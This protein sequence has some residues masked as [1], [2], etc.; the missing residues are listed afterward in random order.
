MANNAVRY[1]PWIITGL[2][3]L[4]VFPRIPEGMNEEAAYPLIMLKVL[5]PGLLGLVL[6]SFFAAFMSILTGALALGMAVFIA[7]YIA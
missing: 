2:A 6:V 7:P 3:T 1:W 4:V 5:G